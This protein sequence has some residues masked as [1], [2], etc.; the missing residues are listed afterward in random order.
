MVP[1]GQ[2]VLEVTSGGGSQGLSPSKAGLSAL[3]QALL[4]PAGSRQPQRTG[5]L[6]GVERS[7]GC[8]CQQGG[9]A[10]GPRLPLDPPPE[11]VL[12]PP[13]AVLQVS[14]HAFPPAEAHTS[15]PLPS[16]SSPAD[17]PS[18]KA[19]PPLRPQMHVGMTPVSWDSAPS[20]SLW[21]PRTAPS[22]IV[23]VVRLSIHSSRSIPGAVETEDGGRS[24][25][26]GPGTSSV[27][28][29][30]PARACGHRWHPQVLPLILQVCDRRAEGGGESAL[31][32]P[33][34]SQEPGA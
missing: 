21:G 23:I 1:E 9:P 32:I 24:K 3:V 33:G 29:V 19:S 2:L 34:K 15:Q 7:P 17:A 18:S 20:P 27:R 8:V 14:A 10:A 26:S 22:H 12:V 6:Q 28:R 5:V 16:P 30:V 4:K 13:G 31:S 25:S 11:P